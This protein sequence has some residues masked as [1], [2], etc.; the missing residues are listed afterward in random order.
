MLSEIAKRAQL[1]STQLTAKPDVMRLYMICFFD[2]DLL[3]ML[4]GCQ[5][6]LL[7]E[8]MEMIIPVILFHSKF[9]SAQI[10]DQ[11]FCHQC[12]CCPAATHTDV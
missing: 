9:C 8:N 11:L 5:K 2:T 3:W 1:H 10:D 7:C 4:L 6:E 12:G